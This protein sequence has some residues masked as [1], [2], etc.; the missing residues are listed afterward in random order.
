MLFIRSS[1]NLSPN[2]HSLRHRPTKALIRDMYLEVRHLPW[3]H[4]SPMLSTIY[5]DPNYRQCGIKDPL[6][7]TPRFC[8]AQL[9]VDKS[10]QSFSLLPVPLLPD[11]MDE[12]IATFG[13]CR[14]EYWESYLYNT[15]RMGISW[16]HLHEG[17]T[18]CHR[19]PRANPLTSAP[20]LVC[21]APYSITS[22]GESFYY[23]RH[24][25]LKQHPPGDLHG[26]G[27]FKRSFQESQDR[28]GSFRDDPFPIPTR[29]SL[30]STGAEFAF[31]VI[32]LSIILI[33]AYLQKL[34]RSWSDDL[35]HPWLHWIE[36]KSA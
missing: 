15:K 13:Q 5:M 21:P 32:S 14:I 23:R 24:Q 9:E 28:M 36:H 8:T 18:K 19:P 2:R 29:R 30:N 10:R 20:S 26:Y 3:Y 17:M 4:Q 22:Q 12:L 16:E 1:A 33:A 25:S 35:D 7:A 31:V 34:I 27:N 11:L 6:G